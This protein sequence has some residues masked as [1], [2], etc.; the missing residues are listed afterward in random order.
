MSLELFTSVLERVE[1]LRIQTC[2]ASQVLGIDLIALVLIGVDEPTF[3][4]I[5][6]QNLVSTLL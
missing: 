2:Q 4:S 6:H 5:G 1:Q 3:T